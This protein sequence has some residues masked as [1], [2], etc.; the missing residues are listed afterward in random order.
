MKCKK[1]KEDIY[2]E[3]LYF[4]FLEKA[5]F[6]RKKGDCKRHFLLFMMFNLNCA[7]QCTYFVSTSLSGFQFKVKQL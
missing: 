6:L 5:F 3:N 4:N 7:V 2:N 1:K